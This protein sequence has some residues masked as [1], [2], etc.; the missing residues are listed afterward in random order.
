MCK[1]R[2]ESRAIAYL[3]QMNHK[4]VPHLFH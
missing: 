4:T 2:N 3:E 1:E